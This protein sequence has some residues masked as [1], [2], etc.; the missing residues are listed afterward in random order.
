MNCCCCSGDQTDGSG[1]GL[2]PTPSPAASNWFIV[3]GGV[4]IALALGLGLGDG[5]GDGVNRVG[6]G[7]LLLLDSS[8][9][10]FREMF[11]K[12]GSSFYVGKVRK[13]DISETDHR[14]CTLVRLC[15]GQKW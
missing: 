8:P 4:L 12:G 3:R 2:D 9:R 13:R 10:K 11:G 1:I 14:A 6:V 5:D 15:H 7:M